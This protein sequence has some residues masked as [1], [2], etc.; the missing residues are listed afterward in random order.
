MKKTIGQQ[1]NQLQRDFQRVED[2]LVEQAKRSEFNDCL[3]FFKR[4]VGQVEIMR[5]DSTLIK[6]YFQ[7]PFLCVHTSSQIRKHIK[8]NARDSDQERILNLSLNIDM[9]KNVMMSRQN[10]SRSKLKKV[11]IKNWRG[12]K[13]LSFLLVGLINLFFLLGYERTT[14]LNR[15]LNLHIPYGDEVFAIFL[16]VIIIIPNNS[17]LLS[18]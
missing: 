15:Y 5:E 3:L 18:I 6:C 17:H 7:I 9:Y 14:Q 16:Q 1:I 11:F 12:I 2:Q 4:F 13:D 8:P 10:Y